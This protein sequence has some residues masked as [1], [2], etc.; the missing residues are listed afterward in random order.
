MPPEGRNGQAAGGSALARPFTRSLT[1]LR[2]Y[3]P[4]LDAF[5]TL[6]SSRVC[7]RLTSGQSDNDGRIGSIAV[8]LQLGVGGQSLAGVSAVAE[9]CAHGGGRDGEV[10]EQMARQTSVDAVRARVGGSDGVR[11]L[12]AGE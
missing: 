3:A 11:T 6:S 1:L 5:R 9:Q 12:E 2:P 7:V 4:L 10:E 8:G